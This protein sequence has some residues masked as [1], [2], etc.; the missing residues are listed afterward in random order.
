MFV[1]LYLC[2]STY[3]KE[4]FKPV[5]SENHTSGQNFKEQKCFEILIY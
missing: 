2:K 5:R 4:Q 1:T 3:A